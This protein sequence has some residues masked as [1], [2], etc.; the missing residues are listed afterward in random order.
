VVQKYKGIGNREEYFI[1]QKVG[2]FFHV[3]LILPVVHVGPTN[4]FP[5]IRVNLISAKV[6]PSLGSEVEKVR[7]EHIYN[8]KSA[9]K[10]ALS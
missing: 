10:K 5:E 3:T 6:E 9:A 2:Q 8:Y 4:L 1:R 7:S